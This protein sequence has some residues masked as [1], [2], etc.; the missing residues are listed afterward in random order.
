[1]LDHGITFAGSTSVLDAALRGAS[2]GSWT[3]G[4][5]EHRHVRLRPRYVRPED[6]ERFAPLY[7]AFPGRYGIAIESNGDAPP[8]PSRTPDAAPVESGLAAAA[9]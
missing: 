5:V 7:R 9:H 8:A 6:A 4:L 1:M 2:G 3:R